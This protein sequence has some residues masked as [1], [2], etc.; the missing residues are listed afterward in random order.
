MSATKMDYEN[1]RVVDLKALT[2]EHGLRGYSQLRK[3][4]LIALLQS[5]PPALWRPAGFRE[6]RPT[7]PPP[8]PPPQSVRFRSDRPRQPISQE[9]DMIEQ[10]EMSKNRPVV[11]SKLNDWYD[12]LVHHIPNTTKDGTS[13]AFKTFKDKIMGLYNGIT[14]NQTQWKKIEEARRA[15]QVELHELE[16]F[17]PIELEQAFNGTYRS[18][19]VN[20]RHR[21]DVETFFSRIRGELIS[22]I[23]REL[24]DLN[25]ARVQTTTWIR[26]IKD[27]DRLELAFNSRMTDVH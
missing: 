27:Y 10:K 24:T 13:R 5:N 19:R 12:W 8:P 2:R 21:M 3:A 25:S 7:R 20:G 22:L 26:F 11:T 17:N 18:Y 16:P 23:T 4:E 14:G 6:W 1:M 15:L 9:M